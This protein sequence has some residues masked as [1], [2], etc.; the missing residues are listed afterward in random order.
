L[1]VTR[2]VINPVKCQGH[3]LCVQLAPD[4]FDLD[5]SGAGQVVAPEVPAEQAAEVHEAVDICPE[6]AI[7]LEA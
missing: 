5:E 4:V 2:A 7:R 3:G 6:G 1:L